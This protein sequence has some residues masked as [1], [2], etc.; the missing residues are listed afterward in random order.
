MQRVVGGCNELWVDAASWGM[1]ATFLLCTH[2]LGVRLPSLVDGSSRFQFCIPP[3]PGCTKLHGW[4]LELVKTIRTQGKEPQTT[5]KEF[6]VV[7][8]AKEVP[9]N[10]V[11]SRGVRMKVRGSAL[12]APCVGRTLR[13]YAPGWV[14]SWS[15]F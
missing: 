10:P 7:G 11:C 13:R 14:S 4:S 8:G 12:R 5:L 9:G 1:S 15:L 2:R 3:S 6:A